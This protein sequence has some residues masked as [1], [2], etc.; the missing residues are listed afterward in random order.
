MTTVPFLDLNRLHQSIRS[1]L[2]R[3]FSS[4][5]ARSSFVGGPD[6]EAFEGA[7]ADIH[8]RAFAVGCGS[9][10]DA[11]TLALLASGIGPGDEV[12]V[13]ATTFVATA[14][15]VV[16][17]GAT[18]VLADVTPRDL[19]ISEES[20]AAV[21]TARTRAVIPVHLY[22]NPVPFDMIARW[23]SSGLVVI[24]DAA[25]AHLANWK[26][27]SIGHAS[28][29]AC[30][31]FY[32]GKNLGALGDGGAVLAD[33]HDVVERLRLLRDHGSASKY[34]HVQV[35]YCSRL[36][37]L[38]AAL[39][40]VKLRHLAEWTEARRRLADRYRSML[41]GTPANVVD[42]SPGAVHH[43][44]VIRVPPERRAD[45]Q[46][47]LAGAG[48]QTGI[49]YPKALSQQR[50]FASWARPCPEAERGASE[51]LSLPMDPLMTEDEV[52]FVCDRLAEA[53]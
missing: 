9:G 27:Q 34:E 10:S 19:L 28:G 52:D 24:E 14:E 43:L 37:G 31:S 53:L 6:V 42:W 33:D 13:P 32:P 22:G 51:V 7:L 46:S 25:Q 17:A 18:P 45:L 41:S 11:L 1:E 47:V 40:A 26:G 23:R 39:L 50:A 4:V 12:I 35:G 21:R 29:L 5:I 49:H 15:A 36:D 20:V 38:Q 48:V 2:D 8:G 30:L 16:L 3:A 44:L